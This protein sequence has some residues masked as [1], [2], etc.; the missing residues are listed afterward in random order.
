[1]TKAELRALAEQ[2]AQSVPVT[3]VPDAK[4]VPHSQLAKTGAES[5][6]ERKC[7][8]APK[9]RQPMTDAEFR[10]YM[11][12]NARGTKKAQ[13][14]QEDNRITVVTGHCGREFYKNADGEWL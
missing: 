1:M 5:F 10:E 8:G 11:E 4:Y 2:A 6:F 7:T 3:K 9:K 13:R 14:E 12:R